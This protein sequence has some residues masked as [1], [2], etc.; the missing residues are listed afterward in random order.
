LPPAER[1]KASL[2]A[3]DGSDGRHKVRV[4]GRVLGPLLAWLVYVSLPDSYPE[5]DGSL[6]VFTNAGASTAAIGVW[7]AV[8]WLSEAISIYATALLPLALMPLLRAA[9]LKE[10]GAS[11]EN[12]S[13]RW[14]P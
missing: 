11:S 12:H 6:K 4:V 7:M 14:T 5:S 13:P 2:E 1:A 10:A 9:G 8:W 3:A